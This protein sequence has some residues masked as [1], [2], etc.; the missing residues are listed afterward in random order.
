M[1][2]DNGSAVLPSSNISL[3][4][5]PQ[6]LEIHCLLYMLKLLTKPYYCRKLTLLIVQ[7]SP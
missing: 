6:I 3:A 2:E 5:T 7:S 4:K 1:K